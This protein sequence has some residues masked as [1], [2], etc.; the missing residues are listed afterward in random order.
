ML[1]PGNNNNNSVP[2]LDEH[3]KQVLGEFRRAIW[4]LGTLGFFGGL[5]VGVLITPYARSRIGVNANIAVPLASGVIFSM[6]GSGYA[7]KRHSHS[8]TYA[9]FKRQESIKV[10][11]QQHSSTSGERRIG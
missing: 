5:C 6:L 9:L 1:S 4:T 2:E 3:D 8:L 11:Q 10:Q 7:A